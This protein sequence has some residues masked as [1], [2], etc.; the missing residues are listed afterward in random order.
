MTLDPLV[1]FGAIGTLL[2][3]I[4][5]AGLTRKWAWGYQLSDMT[6]ER[7]FWRD[8]FLASLSQTEDAIT[9]AKKATRG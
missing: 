1:V 3:G 8:A 2:G 6:T 9:V 5:T 4:V 7:D